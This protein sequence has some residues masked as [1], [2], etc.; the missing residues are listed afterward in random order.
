VDNPTNI[1]AKLHAMTTMAMRCA[2]HAA[3]E[4]RSWVQKGARTAYG[5]SIVFK[6][7]SFA[8]VRRRPEQA[9]VRGLTG[10]F[11]PVVWTLVALFLTGFS[12]QAVPKTGEW[13]PGAARFERYVPQLQGARVAVVAHAASVV[14]QGDQW[15]H[16]VDALRDRGIRVVKVFAPEH[17]F[18]STASAGELVPN[19]KD[20]KTGL[21]I[22]SLYG[23][24]KKPT[25]ADLKDVDVVVFDLQDVG[26][27][28][29]T[30]ISTLTYVMEACAAYG[31]PL[32]VLDRPNPNGD[33]LDGPVLDTASFKSFVGMHAVPILYG[34]TIGEYAGMVHGEG[35]AQTRG[36]QLS[37]VPL[38]RYHR[39]PV[40]LPVPPSPNLRTPEALHAYPSLCFF[41]GTP[42][43]VGRGTDHPF[44]QY[45]APWYP[46]K[47]AHRFVPLSK[48]GATDP[49]F[50]G[51][52]CYGS[53]YAPVKRPE[54]D[55]LDWE[56]L[57]EMYK[58]FV[59]QTKQD[60]AA[61]SRVDAYLIR[62]KLR[63]AYD[64]ALATVDTN[65]FRLTDTTLGSFVHTAEVDSTQFYR[66][67]RIS[68]ADRK[69]GFLRPFMSRLAG[70]AAVAQ[71][72]TEG[73]PIDQWPTLWEEELRQFEA[74][75]R[76]YLL[77]SDE[78]LYPAYETYEPP[79]IRK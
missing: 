48:P 45:G 10:F 41:E 1:T 42:V 15:V 31:K 70:T 27:R 66:K 17:G 52:T 13:L 2:T 23:N 14:P 22:V 21:P 63:Q 64:S 78:R 39:Q 61:Q 25:A 57:A 56:P 5:D 43:S 37:V 59:A 47:N 51:D 67:P 4:V 3:R 79:K 12:A 33:R 68:K 28:F 38:D 58:G 65:G 76:L 26:A 35:W 54:R 19:G 62:R 20:E 36:L 49:L 55:P 53:K 11:A 34:M 75:R 72:L 40:A 71:A 7:T 29:Y 44:E 18:R 32:V 74:V 73:L 16:T 46:K 6:G 8:S 9:P 77:Y 60:D 30:Y 50:R 69:A 24:H